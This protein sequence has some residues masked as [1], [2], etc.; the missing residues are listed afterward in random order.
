[1][2]EPVWQTA[3]SLMD[4]SNEAAE[5]G[6]A[7]A[8]GYGA[9]RGKD[10]LLAAVALEGDVRRMPLIKLAEH[11]LVGL[12]ARF[13]ALDDV[14]HRLIPSCRPAHPAKAY[15]RQRGVFDT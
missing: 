10:G 13:D 5:V 2:G 11:D 14:R 12:V 6:T 15:E 3:F 7:P 9:G 8:G 4:V 1:V